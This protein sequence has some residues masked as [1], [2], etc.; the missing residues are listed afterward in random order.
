MMLSQRR[1]EIKLFE[2]IEFD[3]TG[4]SQNLWQTPPK[5]VTFSIDVLF[6]FVR[7]FSPISLVRY[8]NSILVDFSGT[9]GLNFINVLRTAFTLVDPKS[10]KRH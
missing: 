8:V 6:T 1:F 4:S 2:I 9:P 10:V 5:F 7:T 3:L